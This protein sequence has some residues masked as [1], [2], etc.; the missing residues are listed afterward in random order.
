MVHAAWSHNTM[1]E[2]VLIGHGSSSLQIVNVHAFE[3]SAVEEALFGGDA[4]ANTSAIALRDDWIA[5]LKTLW[6][7]C[8]NAT[9]D[10]Y[11]LDTVGVQIV[12]RPGQVSH[13]LGRQDSTLTSA[14]TGTMGSSGGPLPAEVAAVIRWKSLVATRHARGRTYVAPLDE[15]LGSSNGLV[16]AGLITALDAYATALRARYKPT[17]A[18]DSWN[19]T[20]YSR[21]Y[22][23]PHGDYVKRVGG[24]LTVV[25][26]PDYAGN[27]NFVI[28]HSVDGILRSQRRRQVGVGA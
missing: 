19:L 24:T 20:I 10:A 6:L 1:A 9:G 8:H 21:P 17:G 12:E 23:N 13:R 4:G 2:L 16:S 18:H 15:T 22:D 28:A 5:N 7:A 26:K 14:N 27:S 25:S 3:A 11:K